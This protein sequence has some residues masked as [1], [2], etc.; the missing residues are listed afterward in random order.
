MSA[1]VRRC[2]AHAEG[3]RL[4]C[5]LG[6]VGRLDSSAIRL[7]PARRQQSSGKPS[8]PLKLRS[9]LC[10]KLSIRSPLHRASPPSRFSSSLKARLTSYSPENS[11]H[12]AVHSNV[13]TRVCSDDFTW[14]VLFMISL[15]HCG[16]P[17]LIRHLEVYLLLWHTHFSMQVMICS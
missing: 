6:S 5:S 15:E 7:L 9:L 17:T 14:S 11:V 13:F 4:T 8:K 3:G 2:A 16:L 10:I 12:S 1:P